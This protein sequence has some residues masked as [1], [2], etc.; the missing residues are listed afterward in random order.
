MYSSF[1]S[2]SMTTRTLVSV[3]RACS[4]QLVVNTVM[5]KAFSLLLFEEIEFIFIVIVIAISKGKLGSNEGWEKVRR[6]RV[7]ND[8]YKE[9][10]EIM[11]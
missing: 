6:S 1:T 7:R 4:Q 9:K 2:S 3:A 11:S 10:S 5:L 8:E